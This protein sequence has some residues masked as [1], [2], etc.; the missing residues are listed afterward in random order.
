[1][2]LGQAH[3]SIEKKNISRRKNFSHSPAIIH[4]AVNSEL[5]T[6]RIFTLLHDS[7][8][9]VTTR[10][11]TPLHTAVLCTLQIPFPRWATASAKFGSRQAHPRLYVTI[12]AHI[13]LGFAPHHQSGLCA[14][15]PYPHDFFDIVAGNCGQ[16]GHAK[17]I[18]RSSHNYMYCCSCRRLYFTH[19]KHAR[20]R[21]LLSLKDSPR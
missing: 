13:A 2:R 8:S 7:C 21:P 15:L 18:L 1:M 10:L 16:R 9:L 5:L 11:H 17:G 12:Q 6:E 14:T 4:P 20:V 3:Q 19:L